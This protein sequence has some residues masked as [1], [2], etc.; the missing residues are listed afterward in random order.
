[1]FPE[2]TEVAVVPLA[3]SILIS[4]PP[5]LDTSV[6]ET[7]GV[8]VSVSS[9]AWE[10]WI[11]PFPSIPVSELCGAVMLPD[12]SARIRPVTGFILNGRTLFAFVLSTQRAHGT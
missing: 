3:L 7:D 8:L 1:M 10:R 6:V 4:N 5:W 11:V 2:V 12:T 9:S